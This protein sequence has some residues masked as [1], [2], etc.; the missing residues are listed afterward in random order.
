MADLAVLVLR[1]CLGAVFV[2]HGMQAAFGL[3]GG[4]GIGGFSKMLESLGFMPAL[5]WAYAGAYVE[6]IGG[7]FILLGILPRIAAFFLL[8]FMIVAATRVHLA[9]GF[10]IQNGGFEYN[11]VLACVCIALML[12]GG[13]KFSFFDKF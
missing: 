2:G 13:G 10:F 8:V 5:F 9:K 6:L 4:P 12:F 11:F 3:F 7:L 1:I